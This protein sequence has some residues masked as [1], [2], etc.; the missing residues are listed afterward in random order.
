MV[1][2]AQDKKQWK[3]WNISLM[4]EVCCLQMRWPM[5]MFPFLMERN[6]CPKTKT[7]TFD[8]I[9]GP[10]SRCFFIFENLPLRANVPMS[11]GY[12][13]FTCMVKYLYV[14]ISLSSYFFYASQ[15]GHR[16][17]INYRQLVTQTRNTCVVL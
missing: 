1:E 8:L 2:L 5:S 11:G 15:S 12:Q 16:W 9:M 7:S 10:V 13:Q 14:F 4:E 6:W 17:L 3:Q